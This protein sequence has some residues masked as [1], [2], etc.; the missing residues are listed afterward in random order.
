MRGP[1][2][3][4]ALLLLALVACRTPGEEKYG[5]SDA[6]LHLTPPQAEG[7]RLYNAH[8]LQCHEAYTTRKRVAMTMAGLF[9]KPYLPSGIP[10]NDERTAEVILRGK[11]MMPPTPISPQQAQVILAYLHTL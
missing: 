8:C 3:A 7:R 11:R 10:A 2:L 4:V 6:D 5:M 9:R 1:L